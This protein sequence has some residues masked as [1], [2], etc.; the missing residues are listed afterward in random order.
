MFCPKCGRNCG[1]DRFCMACGTQIPREME[2]ARDGANEA[3]ELPK[4]PF[5]KNGSAKIPTSI[6]YHG[7]QGSVLLFESS[8]SI[9]TGAANNKKRTVI[10][11]SELTTAVFLRPSANGWRDGVF[12]LRGKADQGDPIPDMGKMCHDAAAVVVPLEKATLFYHLFCALRAVAPETAEFRMIVPENKIRRLE[13]QARSVDFEYYWNTYAPFRDR[14]ARALRERYRINPKAAQVLI[15]R[16]F[17]W[18]QELIYKADPQD[19]IRD[20]NLLVDDIQNA[21]RLRSELKE[22]QRQEEVRKS[23]DLISMKLDD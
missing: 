5:R 18:R 9:C 16:E 20:L 8:V 6:G 15:D 7:R 23:L 12:L 19:A 10:P 3:V 21:N 13:E 11:F 17:D 14:A 1:E 2:K 22:Y 4:R